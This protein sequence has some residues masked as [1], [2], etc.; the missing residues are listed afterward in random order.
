MITSIVLGAAVAVALD[1]VTFEKLIPDLRSHGSPS[2]RTN[3]L[4]GSP[5][6]LVGVAF[7]GAYGGLCAA[8]DLDGLLGV[9]LIAFLVLLAVRFYEIYPEQRAFWLGLSVLGCV[10]AAS[11]LSEFIGI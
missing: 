11:V 1:W 7:V 6:R 4:D 3:Y 2:R 5:Y 10:F 9:A 8:K